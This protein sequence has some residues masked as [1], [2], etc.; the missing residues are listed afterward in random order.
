MHYTSQKMTAK[1]AIYG[2]DIAQY[3]VG[4]NGN[5][6]GRCKWAWARLNCASGALVQLQPMDPRMITTGGNL[7][8]FVTALEDDIKNGVAVSLGFEAPMWIP[9]PVELPESGL[10]FRQRFTQEAGRQWYLQA[11]AAATVKALAFAKLIFKALLARI[12]GDLHLSTSCTKPRKGTLTLFEGFVTGKVYKTS[13]LAGIDQ[14]RWDALCTALAYAG[15]VVGAKLPSGYRADTL[16]PQAASNT[17]SYSLWMFA[18]RAAGLDSP[19]L[20]EPCTVVG[21]RAV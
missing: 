8:D 20:A 3:Q 19:A 5:Q 12:G 7:G 15:A 13:P 16:F 1:V 14:D 6:I 18:A 17:E 2:V 11:G 21:L 9:A 10:L 4:P